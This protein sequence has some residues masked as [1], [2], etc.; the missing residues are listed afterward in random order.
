MKDFARIGGD[1]TC[2]Q[3]ESERNI[4]LAEHLARRM[5][6]EFFRFAGQ[7]HSEGVPRHAGG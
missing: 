1:S 6:R 3:I 4:F 2:G 7:S 5:R